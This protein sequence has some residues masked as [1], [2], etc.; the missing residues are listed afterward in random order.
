MMDL[1]TLSRIQSEVEMTGYRIRTR[2]ARFTTR[3][4]PMQALS[5]VHPFRGCDPSC[6]ASCS[7]S[8]QSLGYAGA[9]LSFFLIL[10]LR[11]KR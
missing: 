5:H 1:M 4:L 3:T 7:Q 10:T 9:K 2:T 6:D 11:G 8:S